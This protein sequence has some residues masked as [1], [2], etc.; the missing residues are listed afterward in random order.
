MKI[1][2]IIQKTQ[3]KLINGV[4]RKEGDQDSLEEIFNAFR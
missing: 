4:S 1:E 2:N 3:C